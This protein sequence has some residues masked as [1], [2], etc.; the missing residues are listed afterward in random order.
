M[1]FYA[2]YAADVIDAFRALSVRVRRRRSGVLWF[3]LL[4]AG[5]VWIALKLVEISLTVG[6]PANLQVTTGTL[7][8]AAFFGMLAKGAVDAYHRAIH[9]ESLVLQL[10]QPVS[11][12]AV[13]LGKFLTVLWFN[14]AFVAAALALAVVF[15]ASGIRVPLPWEF[16]A[17]LI[18]AVVSGLASGF[19]LAVLGSLSTWRRKV[20]GLA[21]YA[22]V[23]GF[24]YA[25]L[26]AADASLRDSVIVLVILAAVSLVAVVASAQFLVEAWNNQSAGRRR[27]GKPRHYVRLAD[28]KLEALV[29]LELKTMVRKRQLLLTFGTILVVG[30]AT[31]STYSIVG[32]PAGLPPS[33]AGIF[34]PFIL[35][36]SIYVAAATQLTVPGL[37]ALGKEL[38]RL[39]IVRSLPVPGRTAYSAKTLAI[40]LFVPAVLLG[41]ALPLPILAGFP[42]AVTAFIALVSLAACLILV[43]LGV[44]AGA[45]S[46]NFDP[47]TGGLP[48]SIAMYNVFLAALVLAFL[49]IAVPAGVYQFDRIL[50]ILAA[51]LVAD[52]AALAVVLSAKSAAHRYDAT[53]A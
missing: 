22:P 18:L 19:A 7:L 28:A 53:Q 29:D 27:P 30:I 15:V 10:K 14:L 21:S 48:D 37:A 26:V 25:S 24:G 23:I 35:A 3:A 51:V 12:G 46:P 11:R 9:P 43:A 4:F 36:A 34:Y 17:S 33:V 8:F 41:V 20:A 40:L 6:L 1:S 38:D 45:R 2:V 39:W 44:F 42:V 16:A 50:G 13:A 49:V 31:L 5:S 52:L 32:Q 47:N